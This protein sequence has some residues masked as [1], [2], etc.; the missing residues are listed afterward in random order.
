MFNFKKIMLQKQETDYWQNE[1]ANCR[2]KYIEELNINSKLK[3]EIRKLK[4]K[5][6][7]IGV[8]NILTNFKLSEGNLY[9]IVY[10]KTGH[11]YNSNGFASLE[12]AE[13]KANKLAKEHPGSEWFIYAPI[14][15]VQS[16]VPVTSEKIT[17]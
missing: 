8:N 4:T 6:K 17:H 5:H 16:D 13:E 14:I 11:F 2:I 7:D 12:A 3:E 10:A 1:Y 15:S 9:E